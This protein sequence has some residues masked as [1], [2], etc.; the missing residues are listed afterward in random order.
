MTQTLYPENPVLLVDDEQS[1]LSA[2]SGVLKSR[3]ISNVLTCSDSRNVKSMIEKHDPALLLLDLTMPGIPGE[4][5]LEEL[6]TERPWLPIIIITGNDDLDSAVKCMQLGAVD[7][8]VK[9][10]EN[11]KLVASVRNA[12]RLKELHEENRRLKGQLL[13]PTD[14]PVSAFGRI[15]TADHG[16]ISTFTYLSSV[17]PL[18]YPILIRGE[19]GTGKELIAEAIHTI[20]RREGPFVKINAA[21]L[22]D[23]MFSDA[24]FG[25]RKGAYSGAVEKRAGLVEQASGGTLFLD[26]IGDLSMGSQV[27]LLRLIEQGEYYPLGSDILKTGSC[28][29]IAATHHD[30]ETLINQGTFRK[31][32]YYR[33]STYEVQIPPLRKRRADI[34]LLADLFLN[35]VSNELKRPVPEVK[36]EFYKYLLSLPLPGNVRELKSIIMNALA[37]STGD[38]L[39]IDNLETSEPPAVTVDSGTETKTGQNTRF[40]E[41]LPTLKECTEN[42]IDEA[43]IRSGGNISRAAT[44][45][46]ISQPAL[47]RRLA[48]RSSSD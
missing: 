5:L 16:M 12:L 43:L 10:I 4:T 42:L 2:L 36:A 34:P 27:K 6:G 33:L 46:G 35:E 7:Y 21:G 22:D 19:T 30:L 26:E 45:L 13:A 15:V 32:L 37:R 11:N 3:G 8:L 25:H 9:A 39:T 47:S 41:E 40:T 44:L 20:S 18:P 28:R 1:V 23:T 29:I 31:D 38:A 14:T 17:A 48:R 24:L